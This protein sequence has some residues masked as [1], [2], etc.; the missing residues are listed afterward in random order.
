MEL[1][2]DTVKNQKFDIGRTINPLRCDCEKCT[3]LDCPK[4]NYSV[5]T[6]R[7]I[8]SISEFLKEHGEE[9]KEK[10]H[11]PL[12]L[13]EEFIGDCFSFP[14]NLY[15]QFSYDNNFIELA[16]FSVSGVQQFKAR[17]DIKTGSIS[18]FGMNKT[19]YS[20]VQHLVKGLQEIEAYASS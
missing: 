11:V 9:I 10:R 12:T 16:S 3:F 5:K 6:T 20:F 13:L 14:K 17:V 18:D 2:F 4:N 1:K 15:W 8:Y 7:H 19:Q